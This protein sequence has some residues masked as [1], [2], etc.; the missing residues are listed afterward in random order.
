MNRVGFTPSGAPVQKKMWGPLIYVCQSS[1]NIGHNDSLWRQ[2]AAQNRFLYSLIIIS[3]F[4]ACYH[5]ARKYKKIVLLWGPLFVGPLFGRTCWTCLNPRLRMNES[6]IIII[7]WMQ[8]RCRNQF[9]SSS[10][11][12]RTPTCEIVTDTDRQT[13]RHKAIAGTALA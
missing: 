1:G 13:D 12:H 7:I 8:L 9:D 2:R 11:F 6:Y 5:V 3:I 10:R 4:L